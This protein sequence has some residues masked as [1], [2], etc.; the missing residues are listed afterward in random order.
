[1]FLAVLLGSG[2]SVPAGMPSVAEITAQVLSGENVMRSGGSFRIADRLPEMHEP[3]TQPVREVT[4][5][6]CQV[7]QLC[8]DYF[9]S[10]DKDRVPNYEDISYIV[11]QI[12]DGLRSSTKTRRFCR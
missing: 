9:A 12:S 5:F 11:S 3:F 6:I 2:A 4:A 1:M 10:Q 8:V 7:Q